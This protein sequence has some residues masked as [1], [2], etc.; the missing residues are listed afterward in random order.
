MRTRGFTMLEIV[1][2]IAIMAVLI[3]FAGTYYA[4]SQVRADINSQA[5]N[6]IHYLRLA[7]SNAVSGLD[8]ANH[9]LHFETSSYTTFQGDSY[10]ANDSKNFKMDLP[11]SITINGINLDTGGSD[12]IFL[13]TTGETDNFG[14]IVLNSAAI[15]KTITIT[16]NYVG[17]VNY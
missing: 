10:N 14:T 6:I 3:G 1:L 7:Q 15:N 2:T 11:S 4:N 8:N 17:T 12:V 5:A 16:I 13:K 9:G